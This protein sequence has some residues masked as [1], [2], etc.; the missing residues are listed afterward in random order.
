M[1]TNFNWDHSQPSVRE[2]TQ[3]VK[4]SLEW[5]V[6]FLR[7]K[8]SNNVSLDYN[9]KDEKIFQSDQSCKNSFFLLSTCPSLP[10]SFSS[11]PPYILMSHGIFQGQFLLVCIQSLPWLMS[12]TPTVSAISYVL[13]TSESLRSVQMSLLYKTVH[14]QV[15]PGKCC[16]PLKHCQIIVGK[17]NFYSLKTQ[18]SICNFHLNE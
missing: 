1:L 7:K 2:W 15:L 10:D 4:V 3:I 13:K 11:I 17:T 5:I 6:F 12:P 18:F 16:L 14:L 9:Q 8:N